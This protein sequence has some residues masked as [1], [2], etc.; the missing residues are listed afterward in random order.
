MR[1]TPCPI[2]WVGLSPTPPVHA[3]PIPLGATHDGCA[4]LPTQLCLVLVSPHHEPFG[5]LKDPRYPFPA[6]IAAVDHSAFSTPNTKGECSVDPPVA[7]NP[8]RSLA[9]Y[10]CQVLNY[11]RRLGFSPSANVPNISR[12]GRVILPW[13]LLPDWVIAPSFA[14]PRPLQK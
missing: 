3:P 9:M 11:P 5:C 10:L 6:F 2:P 1:Q 13:V 8:L 12:L 4:A 7:R 14:V